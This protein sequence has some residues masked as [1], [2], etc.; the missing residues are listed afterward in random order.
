MAYSLHPGGHHKFMRGHIQ[1]YGELVTD[2]LQ[3]PLLRSDDEVELPR[4]L[5]ETARC[6]RRTLIQC[7][8]QSI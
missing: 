2:L 3:N 6:G 7:K 5:Q 1:C 8:G 4:R